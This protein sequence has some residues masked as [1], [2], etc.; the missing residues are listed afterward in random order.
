[1]HNIGGTILHTRTHGGSFCTN[2]NETAM[3]IGRKAL[4]YITV[5]L[6][7]KLDGQKLPKSLFAV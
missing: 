5:V 7:W 2:G 4:K 1:M 6:E 3:A